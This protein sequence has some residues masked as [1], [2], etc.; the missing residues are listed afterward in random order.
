MKET[1]IIM[2][3]NHPQLILDKKKTMTRRTWGLDKINTDPENWL[4][5][6]VENG[7]ACFIGN[8]HQHLDIKC[9][10]GGVGDRL[11]VRATWQK[12]FKG[13]MLF[14]YQYEAI[15]EMFDSGDRPDW[16]PQSPPWPKLKWKP[17]IHLLKKDAE[18]WLEITG[19]RAERLQDITNDDCVAEGFSV[20]GGYPLDQFAAVWDSLNAK[21]GL[22]YDFNPWV[23]P[24]GFK[25]IEK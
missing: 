19:L 3:G 16:L 13:Q 20:S 1:G 11:W 10:Y 4:L 6:R 5:S 9:P 2:S 8:N 12:N 25:V 24:I 17:S 23:W 15:T 21:R 22:S 18:I 7:L 14:K